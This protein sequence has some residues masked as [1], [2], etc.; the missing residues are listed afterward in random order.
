MNDLLHSV[1][2]GL[3]D[4]KLSLIMR[5][6]QVSVLSLVSVKKSRKPSP[7]DLL[8]ILVTGRNKPRWEIRRSEVKDLALL[9]E[10]IKG[11][12]DLR[13]RGR[14]VPLIHQRRD[15]ISSKRKHR[16]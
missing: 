6:D 10:D 1:P 7:L 2:H 14:V 5:S 16:D 13:D 3:Q 15:L 9:D 8:G 4:H 12:H 11:V